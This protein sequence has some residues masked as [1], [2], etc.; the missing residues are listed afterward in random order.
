M[1]CD[2]LMFYFRRVHFH[3]SL[4]FLFIFMITLSYFCNSFASCTNHKSYIQPYFGTNLVVRYSFKSCFIKN[5]LSM[6]ELNPNNCS[7]TDSS[8]VYNMFSKC[9]FITLFHATYCNNLWKQYCKKKTKSY[10]VYIIINLK[11]HSHKSNIIS[12]NLQSIHDSFY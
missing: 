11:T 2:V 10:L 1:R 8:M 7:K 5:D 12:L 4:F 9:I 3:P 6:F